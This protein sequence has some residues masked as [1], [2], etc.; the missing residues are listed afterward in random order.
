MA[1]L[2]GRAEAAG[3]PWQEFL[4]ALVSGAGAPGGLRTLAEWR[5][6]ADELLGELERV[7]RERVV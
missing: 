2:E 5:A 4:E 6:R 1:E 3:V 7:V